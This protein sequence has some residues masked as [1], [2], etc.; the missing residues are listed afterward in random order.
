MKTLLMERSLKEIPASSDSKLLLF[1]A[2]DM[3]EDMTLQQSKEIAPKQQPTLYT[4]PLSPCNPQF[5]PFSPPGSRWLPSPCC[6]QANHVFPQPHYARTRCTLR[7]GNI[8][9]TFYRHISI[10][11]I[12]IFDIPTYPYIVQTIFLSFIQKYFNIPHS[13]ICL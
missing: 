1:K 5:T 3:A 10:Q 13:S 11:H 12:V 8:S 4:H 2:L 7:I 6:T 9:C